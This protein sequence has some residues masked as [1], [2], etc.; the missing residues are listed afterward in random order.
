MK[1]S[2]LDSIL[3]NWIT[4]ANEFRDD[5]DFPL[6]LLEES[7]ALIAR[8]LGNEYLEKLLIVDP[9]PL[10]IIDFESNPLA[11]W[12]STA[13]KAKHII[14]VAELAAYLKVFESDPALPD[15]L[16]KL[17]SDRFTSIVFELATA[18]RVKRACEQHQEVWLNSESHSSIG[19]F[20]LSIPG[21]LIPCECSR[22][23]HSPHV[24]A[25]SAFVERLHYYVS[26]ATKNIHIPLCVKIKSSD[27]LNGKIYNVVLQL[28][29]K[30]IAEISR[31]KLPI[32]HGN[33]GCSI[34][35]E[36]L[37]EQSDPA[38]LTIGSKS[39]AIPPGGDWSTSAS[40]YGLSPSKSEGIPDKHG[41]NGHAYG[42]E[43][44]R[45]FTTFAG[46][47]EGDPF[48]RL[49]TKLK[50]KLKQ[51]KIR[52][53]HFGKIIFIQVPFELPELDQD[54]LIKTIDD[55][56]HGTRTTV[57]VVIEQ[58]R[59]SVF[60]RIV[61]NRFL[62]ANRGALNARPELRSLFERLAKRELEVDPILNTPYRRSA[63]EA[64]KHS[65]RLREA[66]KLS[67]I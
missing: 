57:A 16:E 6:G 51:T 15:K 28:L 36:E 9:R 48:A 50:H 54:K 17:K 59:G 13:R 46:M 11:T 37:T 23:G 44:I 19:D 38:P 8:R 55:V 14:Q 31:S 21:A 63:R 62:R 29:R 39:P 4:Q 49:R 35:I 20:T 24:L 45:I 25:A 5:L 60:G 33:S 32:E 65:Q 67:L 56:L 30:G 3:F 22:L 27:H 26:N 64:E 41:G 61:Y 34:M 53:N 12:L 40:C 42:Y 7:I 52:P 1:V 10:Q 43:A 2:H 66:G 58:R 18:S 47:T